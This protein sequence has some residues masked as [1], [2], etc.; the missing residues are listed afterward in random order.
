VRGKEISHYVILQ[1]VGSGGMGVVYKAEDTLLHRTVALKLLPPELTHLPNAKELLFR[2]A[3]AASHFQHQNI[4]TIHEIGE[5]DDGQVFI[6]MDYYEG[7]TLKDRISRLRS[8]RTVH[9]ELPE[10]LEIAIQIALGLTK[11]HDEGIIHRDVKP[12]NVIITT[13]GIVKLLDFGIAALAGQRSITHGG[14]AMGTVSYLSPEQA[15]GGEVDHRTDIWSLGVVLYEMCTN[16]LPFDHPI[17]AAVIYAILDKNPVSPSQTGAD[18]PQ[19]LEDAILKCLQKDPVDRYQSVEELLADLRAIRAELSSDDGGSSS[20][21][22][23]VDYSMTAGV[24]RRGYVNRRRIA[25]A[26]IVLVLVA[27]SLAFFWPR[28]GH[29]RPSIH[30]LAVLPLQ[31]LTN[32]NTQDFF[33]SGIHEELLTNLAKIRALKV[34][35]KTSMMRYANTTEPASQIARELNVDALVEGS[36][37]RVKDHV[38]INVQLIDAAT[39]R[40]L[41]AQSY[42]RDVGDVLTMLSEVARAITREIAINISSE[43]IRHFTSPHPVNAAAHDEY[44]RGQYLLF[45]GK[46][47]KLGEAL[48]HFQKATELDPSFGLGYVGQA[49][50]YFLIG[51]FRMKPYTEVIPKARL[52]A[53][54]SLELDEATSEAHAIMSWIK[55]S[56]DWDWPGAA[57][58]FRRSLQLNPGNVIA[59]HAN[60]DYVA[61][62]G[63]PDVG[64]HQVDLA[65]EY[66]PFSPM[67]V[68]PA[69]YHRLFAGRN[70]E[71]IDECRTL[72]A[73]DP[74]YPRARPTLR[75]ALWMKGRYEESIEEYRKTWGKR[76]T[77][78]DAINRGYGMGGPKGAVR[79]LARTFTRRARPYTGDY[80][81]VA[82]LYCHIGEKDSAL[83]WL[84][85]SCDERDPFLINLN[86]DPFYDSL[87][88]DPRFHAL[89]RRI[90]FPDTDQ[91][92]VNE[93]R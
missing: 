33:V 67:A 5:T 43:E 59:L 26:G 63:D 44:L 13:D 56:F 79:E 14:I 72:L 86:F 58:E 81:E 7:E 21:T 23:A 25:I 47:S 10:V 76:D 77:L 35:A 74:E 46:F 41:W 57:Q 24:F 82:D 49:S 8:S 30:S 78:L 19:K 93:Q 37:L 16:R 65:R 73:T 50:A 61:I 12:A 80:L 48:E 70:D 11:A 20:R 45:G 27:A 75:D 85:R 4:C 83:A 15:S 66:D 9:M 1:L 71:V 18:I 55:L 3:Q 92:N 22:H 87:R 84:E 39:D 53:M 40:H 69:V 90:G 38:R 88:T 54:K 64:L 89:Q 52:M 17:D 28:I 32:D 60:A 68:M 2:E 29:N 91:E 51:L 34:I 62:M 31:N 6:C 36:V 42:D